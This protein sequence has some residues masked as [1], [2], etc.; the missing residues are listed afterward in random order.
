MHLGAS[1]SGKQYINLCQG[2]INGNQAPNS[3][4]CFGK[5]RPF[6]TYHKSHLEELFPCPCAR[7]ICPALLLLPKLQ[8]QD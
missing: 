2:E 1:Q 7:R 3:L 5:A 8:L 6:S 4:S